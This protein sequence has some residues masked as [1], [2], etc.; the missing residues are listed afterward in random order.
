M[1]KPKFYTPDLGLPRG[2]GQPPEIPVSQIKGKPLETIEDHGRIV[3]APT[4]K[5]PL[6]LCMSRITDWTPPRGIDPKMRE[7]YCWIGRHAF[8][9]ILPLEPFP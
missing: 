5:C 2:W 6:H 4:A 7:F 1:P 9:R 8:Y 3:K